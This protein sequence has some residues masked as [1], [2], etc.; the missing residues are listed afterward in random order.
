MGVWRKSCD[1]LW[2]SEKISRIN[3]GV[4]NSFLEKYGDAK[5]F[6]RKIWGCDFF[7]NSSDQ[8][9]GIKKY[10]PLNRVNTV[11]VDWRH[12]IKAISR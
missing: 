7:Y 9:P 10:Q 8:V 12:D 3:M 6:L 1:K 2:G 4:R 5:Y 11:R